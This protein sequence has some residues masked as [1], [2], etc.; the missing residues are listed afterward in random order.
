MEKEGKGREGLGDAKR[1][2]RVNMG[3]KEEGGGREV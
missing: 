1:C 3:R 2:G